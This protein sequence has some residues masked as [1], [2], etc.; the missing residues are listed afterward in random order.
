MVVE[1]DMSIPS[2]ATIQ[3]YTVQSGYKLYDIT[4]NNTTYPL[5]V[6]ADLQEPGFKL[7]GTAKIYDSTVL[8]SAAD[9]KVGLRGNVGEPLVVYATAR[10]LLKAITVR[11]EG[12]ERIVGNI[13]GVNIIADV[14]T[15]SVVFDTSTAYAVTLTFYPQNER[16]RVVVNSIVSGAF[17]EIR[18]DNLVS[19]QLELRTNLD[20]IDPKWEESTIDVSWINSV[21]ISQLL[22][23]TPYETPITYR[24]GYRDTGANSDMTSVRYFYVTE[25]VTQQDDIVTLKAKDA[26]HRLDGITLPEGDLI[27]YPG[28]RRTSLYWNLELGRFEDQL[29]AALND[30][31]AGGVQGVNH[32]KMSAELRAYKIKGF[33][34]RPQMSFKDFLA[35]GMACAGTGYGLF[36]VDAGMPKLA[37]DPAG[38]TTWRV[39]QSQLSRFEREQQPLVSRIV[40]KNETHLFDAYMGTGARGIFQLGDDNLEKDVFYDVETGTLNWQTVSTVV[41]SDGSIRNS[42]LVAFTPSKSTFKSTDSGQTRSQYWTIIETGGSPSIFLRDEGVELNIDPPIWGN[43]IFY[44]STDEAQYINLFDVSRR[45]NNYNKIV[46]F[47]WKGDPRWQPRDGLYIYRADGSVLYGLIESISLKHEGG[48]TIADVTIRTQ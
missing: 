36:Y 10:T 43:A 33:H 27:T 1:I 48:G 40:N 18:K 32:I 12:A 31:G 24:A 35:Q 34:V 46:K 3:Q 30:V 19:A 13:D 38:R 16:T 8:A 22:I 23:S 2:D 29:A 15:Q 4:L 41:R 11:S 25:A 26:S 47:S 42:Q 21:D 6:L 5:R 7:D 39:D 28:R 45:T 14:A 44:N 20:V 37:L 9:G 17:F